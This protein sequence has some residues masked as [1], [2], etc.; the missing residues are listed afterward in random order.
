MFAENCGLD[1]HRH[2]L[3]AQPHSIPDFKRNRRDFRWNIRGSVFCKPALFFNN[4]AS[5][6]KS[7]PEVSV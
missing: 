7:M 3:F 2:A 6:K 4:L 1:F 5:Y